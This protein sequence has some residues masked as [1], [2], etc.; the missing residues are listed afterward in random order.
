M[1]KQSIQMFIIIWIS[2]LVSLT[3][4]SALRGN[5]VPKTGPTMEQVYDRLG[6]SGDSKFVT[7][8]SFS[9]N[10]LNGLA[11]FRAQQQNKKNQRT[12][13]LN[14]S[15]SAMNQAFHKVPNPEL[16]LYVYPHLAGPDQLP[17]PGYFT[18]FNVYTR[19]HYLLPNE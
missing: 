14:A 15:S 4:C 19:D 8:S 18:V 6:N 16:R 2:V 1:R 11:R 17:V 7:D 5:V 13:L 9:V 3:G 12:E 10:N